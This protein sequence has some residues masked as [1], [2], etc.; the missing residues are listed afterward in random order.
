MNRLASFAFLLFLIGCGASRQR[1]PLNELEPWVGTW[2]GQGV[3][4]NRLDP[5][6]QWTL[7]LSLKADRLVGVMRDNS[8]EMR[9]QKLENVH[10]QEGVL[11]FKLGFETSRG[12]YVTYQ[13]HARLNGNTL[14]SVFEGREG[15][16]SFEGKWE[17]RRVYEA[18]AS[19]D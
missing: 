19:N 9:K 2:Q 15:G 5:L 14:L 7:T 17:A 16:R 4:E 13:Y 3:R 10:L 6:Q 11:S 12:L 18:G 8:G 1:A